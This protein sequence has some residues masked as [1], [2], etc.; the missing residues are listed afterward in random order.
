[1]TTEEYSEPLRDEIDVNADNNRNRGSLNESIA[2]DDGTVSSAPPRL[3][4]EPLTDPPTNIANSDT[5]NLAVDASNR[6]DLST[7]TTLAN[8]KFVTFFN[9]EEDGTPIASSDFVDDNRGDVSAANSRNANENSMARVSQPLLEE[10]KEETANEVNTES[11]D[12]RLTPVET[13]SR[14]MEPQLNGSRSTPVSHGNDDRESTRNQSSVSVSQ[15]NVNI[16]QSNNNNKSPSRIAYTSPPGRRSITLTLLEEV[17]TTTNNTSPYVLT[18]PFK[19]L[20][21]RRFRSL[22][23]STVRI[24]EESKLDNMTDRSQNSNSSQEETKYTNHGDKNTDAGDHSS[25]RLVNRGIISVSWYEGTTSSEMTQHV[26]NCVLRKLKTGSNDNSGE[27]KKKLED[28]RLLD[29]TV[30]PCQGSFFLCCDAMSLI[31]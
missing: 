12:V 23:L 24:P 7:P 31:A 30:V 4:I 10:K 17:P 3:Q 11:E 18:T 16:H 25:I 28:V 22:S 29:E 27:G 5:S 20:N 19:K 1:M 13:T 6:S 9:S 15:T 8:K 2:K 26:Y 14:W 21:L